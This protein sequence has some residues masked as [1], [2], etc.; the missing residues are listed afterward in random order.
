MKDFKACRDLNLTKICSESA[1]TLNEIE[2]IAINPFDLM[3]ES[4]RRRL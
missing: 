3:D 4:S 2:V 1:E